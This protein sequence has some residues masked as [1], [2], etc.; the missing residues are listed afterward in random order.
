MAYV[1]FAQP[2]AAVAAYE[3]LDGK[4]FQGRLLHVLPAVDRKPKFSV[5]E[6]TG[7][8]K[9]VKEIR[10]AEKKKMAG[11]GFNWGMLY[12]NVRVFSLF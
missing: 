4:S 7:R 12:M 9:G 10:D 1:T 11:K 2:A 6:G 8:K 5:E 3:A